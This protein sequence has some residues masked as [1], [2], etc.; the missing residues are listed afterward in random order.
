[1]DESFNTSCIQI[2][3]N[4]DVSGTGS[5]RIAGLVAI[6]PANKMEISASLEVL[7]IRIP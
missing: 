7:M 1:V 6:F 4:V 2:K 3:W 5:D